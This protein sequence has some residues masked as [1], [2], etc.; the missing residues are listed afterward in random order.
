M[1]DKKLR[2]VLEV[3]GSTGIATIKSFGQ[4]TDKTGKQT[5]A[6]GKAMEQASRNAK[7]LDGAVRNAAG[8]IGSMDGAVKSMLTGLLSIAALKK[9]VEVT[10]AQQNALGQLE[11]A[12]K[13]TGGAAGQSVEQLASFAAAMQKVTTY[14]DETV[15][16]MQSVLLTFTKIGGETFP[17]A[18]AAI[19][20]MAARMKTDLQ[21][22]ALQVGKA[23]ND[24][25]ASLGALSRAGVQFSDSQQEL[26]TN[27]W[28][29]GKAAEA[30]AIILKELEAQFGGSAAAARNTLGG[31][32]EA[33]SNSF[34][35]FFEISENG[36]KPLVVML[37]ALADNIGNLL[38]VSLSLAAA[39]VPLLFGKIAQQVKLVTEAMRALTIAV[40]AN[41]FVALAAAVTAVGTALYFYRDSAVEIAGTT[42]SIGNW[43]AAAWQTVA[44]EVGSAFAGLWQS[45]TESGNGWLS[46]VGTIASG[47][48]DAF[49]ELG[50]GILETVKGTINYVI[51][52]FNAWYQTVSILGAEVP[53]IFSKAFGRVLDIGQAFWS[54]LKAIFTSGDFSFTAFGQELAKGFNTGMSEAAGE[55][56][57]AV[58][59]A[60][61][62]D[63]LGQAGAAIAGLGKKIATT[64]A[65]FQAV[66]TAA[67][68]TGQAVKAFADG[69]VKDTQKLQDALEDYALA[70]AKATGDSLTEQTILHKRFIESWTKQ[71]ISVTNAQALWDA[72][73]LK[74]TKDTLANRA[75]AHLAYNLQMAKYTGDGLAEQAALHEQFVSDW[76]N[77]L[78]DRAAAEALWLAK[79]ASENKSWF[80]ALGEQWTDVNTIAKESTKAAL[81]SIQSTFTDLF[82]NFLSGKFDSL[83][84][85]WRGL[86]DSFLKIVSNALGQIATGLVASGISSLLGL[87]SG[88]GI[89]IGFGT[90]GGGVVSSVVKGVASSA[91]WQGIKSG[92]AGVASYFGLDS[93]ATWLG[94]S[95]ADAALN[96]PVVL[97]GTGTE[98]A[99]IAGA[100]SSS[101]T[102][103]AS[104]GL[105]AALSTPAGAMAIGLLP[106]TIGALFHDQISSLLGMDTDPMSPEEAVSNWEGAAKALNSLTTGMSSL[107]EQYNLFGDFS[108]DAYGHFERL[109][110][111]ANYNAEQMQAAYNSLDDYGKKL[112][113]SGEAVTTLKGQVYELAQGVRQ[114]GEYTGYAGTQMSEWDEKIEALA[115]RLGLADSAV[116]DFKSGVYGLAQQM[117]DGGNATGNFSNVLDDFSSG[118]LGA[119]SEQAGTATESIRSLINA[120]NGVGSVSAT[121]SDLSSVAPTAT[122]YDEEGHPIAKGIDQ[123]GFA[124]YHGGGWAGGPPLPWFHNGGGINA[125]LLPH[126][127]VLSWAEIA[128]MGG[129]SAVDRAASGT[130]AQGITVNGP[131]ISVDGLS[132]DSPEV[133]EDAARK[134]WG[135]I[136][137][138]QSRGWN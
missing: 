113:S 130:G 54:S 7:T 111:V 83:K 41:P 12:V 80:S 71:G 22:A 86:W 40:M 126:E 31:A 103:S 26:I 10:T 44:D 106:G 6:A 46:A 104:A 112:L 131:L 34:W 2:I 108:E 95:G 65:S 47:V 33:L 28:E 92:A 37:N 61:S 3:D 85:L 132:L 57:R 63:Y 90:G 76:E 72:Q 128:R 75:K 5:T 133:L 29:A 93:L 50:T 48:W 115:A 81:E 97:G 18:T 11:A 53:A 62:T 45:L 110:T 66:D 67:K 88:S 135:K 124:Y 94:G 123:W 15:M 78:G 114:A 59:K 77:R 137:E 19:I 134:I 70:M 30:Q 109:G 68:K 96:A 24:P 4:A 36:A 125:T 98:A 102:S 87:G 16:Q 60:L 17:R 136:E 99:E 89:N 38:K 118:V 82:Y 79:S 64:A 27:L 91:A 14:G 56:S 117:G 52:Y 101:S 8:G 105:A 25:V 100:A 69:G 20:D 121:T 58:N 21:S 138:I 49:K 122:Q 51:G 9:V 13:S 39:G 74:S 42:A 43:M 73:Q 127:R 107:N 23:L 32:L 35:D 119:V 120:M 116:N 55:I 84:D 129:P 1:P